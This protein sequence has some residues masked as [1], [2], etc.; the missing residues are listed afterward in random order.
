MFALLFVWID[1]DLS[2]DVYIIETEASRR[3]KLKPEVKCT[4]TITDDAIE[5]DYAGKLLLWPYT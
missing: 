5:I 1:A 4:L 2:E 3:L